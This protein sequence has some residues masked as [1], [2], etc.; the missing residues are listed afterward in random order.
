MHYALVQYIFV[1]FKFRGLGDNP[2]YCDCNL[3]WLSDWIKEDYLEPGIASC[4]DP[5]E[6]RN[7]LL[8]TTPSNDFQCLGKTST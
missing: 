7:N 4:S 8:L 3:K 6:M 1:A 2:F 5:I